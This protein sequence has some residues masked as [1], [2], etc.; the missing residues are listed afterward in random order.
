MKGSSYNNAHKGGKVLELE[1]FPVIP[2][3]GYLSISALSLDK[4]RSSQLPVQGSLLSKHSLTQPRK[5]AQYKLL[6]RFITQSFG[7]FFFSP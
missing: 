2:S 7:L 5:R 4:A 1:R 6:D 3:E